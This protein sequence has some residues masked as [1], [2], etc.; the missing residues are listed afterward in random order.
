MVISGYIPRAGDYKPHLG[1]LLIT[2]SD[3]VTLEKKIS[4]ALGL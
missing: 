2:N 4:S 3:S 1:R